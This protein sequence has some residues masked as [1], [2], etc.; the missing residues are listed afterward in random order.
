MGAVAYHPGAGTGRWSYNSDIS[1]WSRL[2]AGPWEQRTS[3]V[4]VIGDQDEAAQEA[5][6]ECKGYV[7]GS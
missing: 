7:P 1:W 5:D 3:W 4:D 2:P 6:L